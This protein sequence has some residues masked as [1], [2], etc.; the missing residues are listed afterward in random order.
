MGNNFQRVP[1][2][3]Q[4]VKKNPEQCEAAQENLETLNTKCASRFATTGKYGR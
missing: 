1:D 2:K 3:P 4:P